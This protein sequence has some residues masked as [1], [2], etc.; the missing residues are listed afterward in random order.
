MASSAEVREAIV[1]ALIDMEEAYGISISLTVREA[2]HVATA[3]YE[4]L[5][6]K[7][8]LKDD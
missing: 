6:R 5:Q 4:Q 7:G 3:I 8:L 2:G 1:T